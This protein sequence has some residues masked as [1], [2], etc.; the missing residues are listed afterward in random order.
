MTAWRGD[1]HGKIFRSTLSLLALQKSPD[2][3]YTYRMFRGWVYSITHIESGKR[4]IGQ[5][6]HDPP[7][8]RWTVHKSFAR[9]RVKRYCPYLHAAIRKHGEGAFRF[10]VLASRWTQEELDALER[11]LIQ[12]S[13]CTAPNGYNI[14]HGGHGRGKHAPESIAKIVAAHRGRERSAAWRQAIAEAGRRRGMP[15]GFSALL[16][17]A[18][19]AVNHPARGCDKRPVRNLIAAALG[20]KSWS[21]AVAS[22]TLRSE[23]SSAR[24]AAR[25]RVGEKNHNWNGG[26]EATQQRQARKGI[27]ERARA[28]GLAC[29]PTGPW[30]KRAALVAGFLLTA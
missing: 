7:E 13:G 25:L 20:Y 4:Y 27:A 28:S 14:Q 8:K 29:P 5:T 10:E 3:P 17:R 12:E 23:H 15:R 19:S 9:T 11:Q 30:R 1:L 22:A 2:P 18:R 21:G 24:A 16:Y 26:P 6:T